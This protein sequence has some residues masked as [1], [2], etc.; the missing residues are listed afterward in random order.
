MSVN[1]ELELELEIGN[2]FDNNMEKSENL[3]V[4]KTDVIKEIMSGSTRSGS[5]KK[6]SEKTEKAEKPK[7]KV[8][9]KKSSSRK[10]V[11][12]KKPRK[13]SD[14]KSRRDKPVVKKTIKKSTFIPS[15][16]TKTQFSPNF[17]IGFVNSYYRNIFKKLSFVRNKDGKSLIGSKTLDLNK[18]EIIDRIRKH[19]ETDQ[20]D[21]D[22]CDPYLY[23]S[24]HYFDNHPKAQDII[25]LCKNF[26]ISDA[27][28]YDL[29]QMINQVSE[30]ASSNKLEA[31]VFNY[32]F[33]P[34]Y[35]E[36][37]KDRSEVH[38][39]YIQRAPEDLMEL[40]RIKNKSFGATLDQ[41]FDPSKRTLMFKYLNGSRL[42][43]QEVLDY[44]K[45]KTKEKKGMFASMKKSE[46]IEKYNLHDLTT[47]G[48]QDE[49]NKMQKAVSTVQTSYNFMKYLSEIDDH[50]VFENLYNK[51]EENVERFKT[52]ASDIKKM[53]TL[54]QKTS[55]HAEK[56]KY[57]I[58]M[59]VEFG[60]AYR[61]VIPESDDKKDPKEPISTVF[62]YLKKND[63]FLSISKEFRKEMNNLMQEDY[64]KSEA[65][66]LADKYVSE[67]NGSATPHA[68]HPYNNQVYS[69]I[70]Y[71]VMNNWKCDQPVNRISKNL[72]I[73][74]GLTIFK[75]IDM[76]VQKM[77]SNGKVSRIIVNY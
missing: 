16:I 73:S 21:H 63:C 67:S 40:L 13:S 43:G 11:S 37:H 64:N 34:V 33:G 55:S 15:E 50:E 39:R 51:V 12:N 27:N 44:V 32:V 8:S 72:R 54:S 20:V 74:I 65:F 77:M 41:M 38:L 62:S 10:Q 28:V 26:M 31:R 3:D 36:K 71:L 14:K 69:K 9:N 46:I 56:W 5:S 2:D 48:V 35:A 42:N 19:I 29:N 49:I 30:I 17:F 70:G 18:L 47:T 76:E 23:T 66:K 59:L 1:S 60:S 53:Q 24:K 25:D 4:P 6:T 52:A 58:A 75:Y 45:N 61:H 68:Y 57:L 7:R 22:I